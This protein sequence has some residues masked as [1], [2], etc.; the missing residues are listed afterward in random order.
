MTN[1]PVPIFQWKALSPSVRIVILAVVIALAVGI[2]L[3]LLLGGNV[4]RPEAWVAVALAAFFLTIF[5]SAF[6]IYRDHVQAK[7]T[8]ELMKKLRSTKDGSNKNGF[9]PYT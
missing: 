9:A 5:I 3:N 2:G 6:G 1:F 7:R 8:D 4:E